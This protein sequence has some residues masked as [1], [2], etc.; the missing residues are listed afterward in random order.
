MRHP[1]SRTCALLTALDAV[2]LCPLVTAVIQWSCNNNAANQKWLR[3][4]A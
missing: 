2:S 3:T 1:S 4:A